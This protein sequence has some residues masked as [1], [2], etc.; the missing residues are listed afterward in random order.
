LSSQATEAGSRQRATSQDPISNIRTLSVQDT[1]EADKA[2]RDIAENV[3]AAY[4]RQ[5]N[6][7]IHPGV[8]QTLVTRLAEAIRPRLDA[9]AEDLVAIANAVLDDVELTA[10]EMR[11]PRMTSLNPIDRSFTAALR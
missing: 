7:R 9:S 8:E 10:P 5:V 3:L 4:V 11:G 6:S 1:P 2:A